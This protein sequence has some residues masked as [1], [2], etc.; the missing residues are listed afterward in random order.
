M[1]VQIPRIT[2]ENTTVGAV[3]VVVAQ[4]SLPTDFFG[5][6]SI[7]LFGELS[8]TPGTVFQWSNEYLVSQESGVATIRSSAMVPS[9]LDPGALAFTITVDT[10]G[11]DK[12]RV[13]VLGKAGQ[14]WI[15]TAHIGG[16]SSAFNPGDIAG[17]MDWYE[18][19]FTT[20]Q[21]TVIDA[22]AEPQVYTTIPNRGQLG[23]TFGST[24]TNR[25]A[26]GHTENNG[27]LR[28]SPSF[29][30]SSNHHDSNLAATVRKFLHDGTGCT[31]FYCMLPISSGNQ[32]VLNNCGYSLS[33]VGILLY[34]NSTRYD[35]YI[36]NGSGTIN[37]MLLTGQNGSV[38]TG[39]PHIV[40]VY[41]SS[42]IT[43]NGVMRHNGVQ[44]ASSSGNYT[45]ADPTYTLTIGAKSS[46][47]TQ[48]TGGNIFA[49]ITYNRVL[50]AAEIVLVENYLFQKYCQ[51]SAVE[52]Q[53]PTMWFRP[54]IGVTSSSS[55]VSRMVDLSGKA[56]DSYQA[57]LARKPTLSTL[58]GQVSLSFDGVANGLSVGAGIGWSTNNT[59]TFM[60]ILNPDAVALCGQTTQA[61]TDIQTGRF[62][63]NISQGVGGAGGPERAGGYDSSYRGYGRSISGNQLLEWATGGTDYLYRNGKLI[64]SSAAATRQIGGAI[65]IGAFYD[66]SAGW[67]KMNLAELMHRDVPLTGTFLWEAREELTTRYGFTWNTAL[68][69]DS[70]S[71]LDPGVD[72]SITTAGGSVARVNSQH[73][74]ID[75]I[76]DG[77]CNNSTVIWWAAVNT[78]TLTKDATTPYEGAYSLKIAYDGSHANPYARQTVM[79]AGQTYRLKCWMWGDAGSGIPKIKDSAVTLWTGA[80]TAAWQPVDVTFTATGTTIDFGGDF[81]VAGFVKV[82]TISLENVTAGAAVQAIAANQPVHDAA[83]N[84]FTY[85]GADDYLTGPILPSAA[86]MYGGWVYLAALPASELTVLGSYDGTL[87]DKITID[88]AGLIKYYHGSVAA[89]S[90]AGFTTGAWHYLSNGGD[91]T[92]QR[93]RYD[94]NVQLKAN[95][96]TSS[97]KAINF[98]A[99]NNN[100]VADGYMAQRQGT[101]KVYSRLPS[102]REAQ[103]IISQQAVLN[104]YTYAIPTAYVASDWTSSLDGLVDSSLVTAGSAISTWN[105]ALGRAGQGAT[106]PGAASTYPFSSTIDNSIYSVDGTQYMSWINASGAS[107]TIE[108]WVYVGAIGGG[109]CP[110]SAVSGT[111]CHISV[112]AG[113]LTYLYIGSVAQFV[114]GLTVAANSWN[115]M[116]GTWGGGTMNFIV[117]GVTVTGSCGSA[118]NVSLF[119]LARNNAGSPDVK[120]PAGW[121]IAKASYKPTAISVAQAVQ[122]YV[123]DYP[124]IVYKT[125]T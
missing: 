39:V 57:T 34:Q 88:N 54:T 92:N 76:V 105:D 77:N 23:G 8:A 94:A 33:N 50:T 27:I 62:M 98:G 17:L 116:V 7:E 99:N 117:N 100:G 47:Y 107:G 65:A 21:G 49:V 55:A 6:I 37:G 45:S 122:N 28:T 3:T 93:Y 40:T 25:P 60:G 86:C 70:T 12:I 81:G 51:P 119:L 82:D 106:S 123:T 36:Q 83:L 85:D 31:I 44:V 120:C 80:N 14:N 35:F 104:G 4:L 97:T 58:G 5:R 53:A 114:Q 19:D 102:I 29:N 2:G 13:S 61:V 68:I 115:H 18:G 84:Q 16:F 22:S 1:S 52:R 121:R 90:I 72:D 113:G 112:N 56:H 125:A 15:W 124:R 59:H 69:P 64:G 96:T 71:I 46:T 74:N 41:H 24:T 89:G 43:P 111:Y 67:A 108:I 118:P 11:A 63:T 30:S 95:A 73:T 38:V 26:V 48:P 103:R 87:T 78:A 66:F 20:A 9:I 32:Y 79:T 101:M 110:V 10:D 75:V 91:S 42:A 109:G